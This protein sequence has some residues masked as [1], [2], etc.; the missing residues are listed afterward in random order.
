MATISAATTTDGTF[1]NI[2]YTLNRETFKRINARVYSPASKSAAIVETN[3]VNHDTVHTV[4]GN[5]SVLRSLEEIVLLLGG[6]PGILILELLTNDKD[7]NPKSFTTYILVTNTLDCCLADKMNA[8]IN[9]PPTDPMCD[10]HLNDAQKMFLFKQSAEFVL[11]S[12]PNTSG[13]SSGGLSA[14]A[15]AK[16]NDAQGK[17]DKSLELC[18]GTSTGNIY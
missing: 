7:N 10:E 1:L 3:Q 18:P 6:N 12:I 11:R 5:F 15:I 16:L 17:Y 9:C 4:S 8:V 14:T 2:Q 13:F